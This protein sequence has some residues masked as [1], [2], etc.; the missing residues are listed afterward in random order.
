[1]T[2]GQSDIVQ[3]AKTGNRPSG[4]HGGRLIAKRAAREQPVSETIRESVAARRGDRGEALTDWLAVRTGAHG[5]LWL[6]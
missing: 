6:L 3:L 5:F 2:H 1:M 4:E